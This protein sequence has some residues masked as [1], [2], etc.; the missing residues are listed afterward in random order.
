LLPVDRLE[1]PAQQETRN[2]EVHRNRLGVC[3][4]LV[5]AAPASAAQ[6]S[7]SECPADTEP[8]YIVDWP[9]REVPIGQVITPRVSMNLANPT[10]I[11][12]HLVMRGD[13]PP[14]V[15]Y[16]G[17]TVGQALYYLFFEQGVDQPGETVTIDVDWTQSTSSTSMTKCH[18]AVSARFVAT[19]APPAN[20][21]PSWFTFTVQPKPA[22]PAALMPAPAPA[23]AGGK[24]AVV[25][26]VPNV[27]GLTIR[28]ARRRLARAHCRLGKVRR[29][30]SRSRSGRVLRTLPG[31]GAVRQRGAGIRLVVAD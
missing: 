18:M 22:P 19:A 11:S 1:Q 10:A 26:K 20:P 16:E 29:V 23:P 8:A 30:Y 24:A 17:E 9:A 2:E 7:V 12:H 15:I 5:A 4:A 3:A 27:R 6:E 31:R 21:L 28:G 14:R 13:T 25:C